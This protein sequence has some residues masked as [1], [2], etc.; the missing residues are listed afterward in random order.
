ME[1]AV[2]HLTILLPYGRFDEKKAVT[3]LVV[4]TPQGSYGIWPNRLDC[5]A[6]LVPGILTYETASEGE[7]YVAI[8][9]GVM[10]KAGAEVFVSVR[11]AVGGKELGSLREAVEH[12]FLT[13]E[14][15]E[16]E[17]RAVLAKLESGFV[18]QFQKLRKE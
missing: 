6:A 12:E 16:R 17:V 7:M 11:H 8:D 5:A 10:I 13:L 3:R 9:E 1:S 18:R 2:I 14:E 15:R 4:E